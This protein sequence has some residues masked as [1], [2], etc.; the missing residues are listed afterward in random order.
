MPRKTPTNDESS[1][2]AM[3]RLLCQLAEAAKDANGNPIISSDELLARWERNRVRLM[4]DHDVW[5]SIECMECGDCASGDGV[6]SL[7][8]ADREGWTCIEPAPKDEPLSH[9]FGL[10]PEH[11]ADRED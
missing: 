9:F 6:G 1:A 2:E 4:V 5:F 7:E 11:S 10:C 3:V 8:Q